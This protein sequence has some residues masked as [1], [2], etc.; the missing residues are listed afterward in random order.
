M[1]AGPDASYGRGGRGG[2][3][4]VYASTIAQF[5]PRGLLLLFATCLVLH[6]SQQARAHTPGRPSSPGGPDLAT[7]TGTIRLRTLPP[8]HANSSCARKHQPSG[9]SSR[10]DSTMQA[11]SIPLGMS[12]SRVS[13][14]PH[15]VVHGPPRPL[16]SNLGTGNMGAAFRC[17]QNPIL[18][19]S[20]QPGLSCGHGDQWTP[21]KLPETGVK[22]QLR[23]KHDRLVCKA[24]AEAIADVDCQ[25]SETT[26][27]GKSTL[28]LS[29][30]PSPATLAS[31]QG[32][33]NKALI[34]L[35]AVLLGWICMAG[36]F[37]RSVPQI[38]RIWREKSSEGLSI[39]SVVAELLC[40][41][42]NVAYHVTK[43]YDFSAYGEIFSCWVQDIALIGLMLWYM[44][45]SS[46]VS[47]VSLA[48]FAALSAM[49][50]VTEA[51]EPTQML[52]S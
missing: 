35:T 42:I 41:T 5:D 10:P 38:V 17:K 45:A 18:Q 47:L 12:P 8:Y 43:Q 46:V 15:V 36:S 30:A 11:Q 1:G 9:F 6:I 7:L 49:D 21:L 3:A 51:I 48:G 50:Q 34:K 16:A 27:Q 32:A 33:A 52:D 29:A 25:V 28:T 22:S 31:E 23:F 37:F 14:A 24:H 2:K 4:A 20:R 44:R 13:A 40:Y 26:L 19:S 39:T